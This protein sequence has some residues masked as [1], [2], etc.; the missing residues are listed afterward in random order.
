MRSFYRLA[1]WVLSILA[2]AMAVGA[3]WLIVSPPALLSVGTGYA[4]KTV[5]SNV[6]VA[7]RDPAE[8]LAKDVQAPVRAIP[9]CD[10]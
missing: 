6:F 4:A 9:N 2:L 3:S 8:V 7:G 1:A 5:C 10:F